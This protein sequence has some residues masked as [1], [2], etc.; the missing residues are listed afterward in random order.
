[1]SD[2]FDRLQP[3]NPF[4]ADR[5]AAQTGLA[6]SNAFWDRL[7]QKQQE[8]NRKRQENIDRYLVHLSDEQYEILNLAIAN[9]EIPEEEAYNMASAIVILHEEWQK[10]KRR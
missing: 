6:E 1:M 2:L 3:D 7:N 5:S 4:A 9:A 10:A 8:T